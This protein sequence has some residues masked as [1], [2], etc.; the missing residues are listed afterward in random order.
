MCRAKCVEVVDRV[1]IDQATLSRRWI[2]YDQRMEKIVLSFQITR[3]GRVIQIDCDEEGMA[4][5]IA[6][7]KKA[8]LDGDHLHLRTPSNGGRELSEKTKWGEDAVW[9]VIINWVGE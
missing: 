8:Q 9:E 4:T 6:A 1:G 7:V 2:V 5:L 3:Q